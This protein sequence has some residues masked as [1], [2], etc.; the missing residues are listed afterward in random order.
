MGSYNEISKTFR[1]EY[2][3]RS[4]LYKNRL[5]KWSAEPVVVR[6]EKPTNIA[7]ARRLGY[8]AIQGVI[9]AR[10]RVNKGKRKR[11]KA[12]G[13]RKPSKSGRFFSR[14][15]SL[16]R[17]AEEKAARRFSNC[18]VLNSYLVGS[19]GQKAFYEIILLDRASKSV[20]S[21][22]LYKSIISQ[23]GRAFRGV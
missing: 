13:G 9:I 17:I 2:R 16:Q 19:T 11:Q 20:A 8:K 7:R 3:S 10:V 21:N 4:S 23:K 14:A 12:D 22:P 5:E 1:D 6:A 15:K 18:E